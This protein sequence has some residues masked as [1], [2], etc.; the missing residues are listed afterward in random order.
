[1]DQVADLQPIVLAAVFIKHGGFR[2]LDQVLIEPGGA[3]RHALRRGRFQAQ[4]LG[5]RPQFGELGRGRLELLGRLISLR[6]QPGE[7]RVRQTQ[8]LHFRVSDPERLQ[9]PEVV[10]QY[11]LQHFLARLFGRDHFPG[12]DLAVFFG[13][14]AP[15]HAA[16][17][18]P[19]V[20]IRLLVVIGV[21]LAINLDAVE[22]VRPNVDLL[23]AVA[24]EEAAQRLTL[25]VGKQVA[26]ASLLRAVD[27]FQF[28]GCLLL[29]GGNGVG[30]AGLPRLVTKDLGNPRV[31][32][33]G[34]SAGSDEKPTSEDQTRCPACFIHPFLLSAY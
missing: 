33:S 21:D 31:L 15:L 12:I 2:I 27:D 9:S 24:V 11:G 17:V 30:D 20:L 23:V 32:G 13:G 26:V 4:P 7:F 29:R 6:L 14:D 28:A 34:Q 1:M 10:R 5:L 16:A 3:G 8:R 25:G 19:A 18:E 22:I